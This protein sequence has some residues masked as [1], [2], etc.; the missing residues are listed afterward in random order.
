MLIQNLQVF[1]LTSHYFTPRVFQKVNSS[2]DSLEPTTFNVQRRTLRVATFNCSLFSILPEYS[3]SAVYDGI[4]MKMV[5][6]AA[7][8]LNFTWKL[9]SLK[10]NGKWG[11]M[12]P[13]GTWKGGVFGAL[14]DAEADVG[15]CN[16]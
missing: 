12:L 10:G 13:N 4:E 3:N 11:V 15:F 2:G 16:I 8:K 9:V 7:Q 1:K 6:E 5:Q 14:Q